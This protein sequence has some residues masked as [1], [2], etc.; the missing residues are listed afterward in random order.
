MTK[1]TL[2]S[3]RVW[4]DN[5]LQPASLHI[6]GDRILAIKKGIPTMHAQDFG[7]AIIMPGVIDAHVHINEPG[8]THWEGFETATRAAA[9]GGITTVVD[10]PLN[11]SPVVTSV[12]AFEEKL[13]A[14]ENK[15]YVNCGFWAGAFDGNTDHV[16]ALLDAGCLGV[17]VFLC[18]SGLDEFPNISL[19]DLE[20]VMNTVAPFGKPLL[21]HCEFDHLPANTSFAETPTSY[22]AYL[23]S[24]P[25]SWE[26]EAVQTFVELGIKTGCGIHVVHLS[27][28]DLLPWLATQK[29]SYAGLTVETCPHYLL[30]FA[31]AISDG[32]TLLKCAPPIRERANNELLKQGLKEG[33]I[34]F[35]A[36]DHSPAPPEWKAIDSGRFDQAWGGIAGLQYLLPASWTALKERLSLEEF[37]PLLTSRPARF[38]GLQK[39]IG[40]LVE[41]SRADLVIWS[42]ETSFEITKMEN[43]HRHKLTPY[44][45]QE[46]FGRILTT[47]V[48]GQYVWQDGRFGEVK[49]GRII[50]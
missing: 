14:A 31:E 33:T 46:L 15:L 50:R 30:F 6:E 23:A 1:A 24:R 32:S 2:H 38:L 21:A 3:R 8:R 19:S 45:G 47:M 7:E 44:E 41:G 11:S 16:K 29:Q 40:E 37:I 17:K 26:N 36:T 22:Q 10:M 35:I 34:D 18:H 4:I 43:E 12:N 42:P 20:A 9:R 5:Q 49:P 25:K 48:N 13:A 27:S 28:A 39:E